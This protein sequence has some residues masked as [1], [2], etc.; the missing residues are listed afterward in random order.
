MQKSILI[1]EDSVTILEVLS[2]S[3]DKHGFKVQAASDGEKA[4]KFLDGTHFDL[5]ITDLYMPKMDGLELVKKIKSME[6]YKNIPI[7]LLTTETQQNKKLEAKKAGVTGW[8]IK[9][10]VP[11]KLIRA[12]KK[13]LSK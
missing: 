11:E 10:F 6:A 12:I 13:L 9:P 8:V 1:V 3:L 7:L 5:I 4:L 2:F